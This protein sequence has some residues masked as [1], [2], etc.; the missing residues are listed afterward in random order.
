MHYNDVKRVDYETVLEVSLLIRMTQFGLFPYPVGDWSRTRETTTWTTIFE[1]VFLSSMM[2]LLTDPAEVAHARG[3]VCRSSARG[4][5]GGELR[6]C[7]SP[8]TLVAEQFV[9]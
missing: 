4:R 7:L 1:F 9:V 6:F 5:R 3:A 8:R 2:R